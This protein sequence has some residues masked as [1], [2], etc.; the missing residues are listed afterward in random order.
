M[1]TGN[2]RC[3]YRLSL[4][5]RP[6][7][8]RGFR[9]PGNHGRLCSDLIRGCL[10]G[11]CWWSR[12]LCG[13]SLRG[14]G[15]FGFARLAGGKY[16]GHRQA[17]LGCSGHFRGRYGDRLTLGLSRRSRCRAQDKKQ[18][19]PQSDEAGADAHTGP[20]TAMPG[21]RRLGRAVAQGLK[22][23]GRSGG[24]GF[25]FE[26]FKRFQNGAHGVSSLHGRLTGP[27]SAL[28]FTNSGAAARVWGC[29]CRD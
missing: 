10:R 3:H 16:I 13:R 6:G 21:C 2:L 27:A 14:R 23:G 20:Q 4:L 25:L 26:F 19:Q 15:R 1:E 22:R 9:G 28:W 5:L 11:G 24:L 7:C 12:R 29:H 17:V 18:N 8:R